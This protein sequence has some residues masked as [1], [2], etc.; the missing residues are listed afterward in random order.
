[1]SEVEFSDF[2][3]IFV[4]W[5]IYIEVFL[6]GRRRFPWFFRFFLLCRPFCF[7][8]LLVLLRFTFSPLESFRCWT[9]N[10]NLVFSFLKHLTTSSYECCCDVRVKRQAAATRAYIYLYIKVDYFICWF[11]LL[12]ILYLFF[13]STGSPLLPLWLHP[14]RLSPLPHPLF[15]HPPTPTT[16]TTTVFYPTS[17]YF[18]LPHH[19]PSKKLFETCEDCMK[20]NVFIYIIC[21][22]ITLVE[23]NEV[24][25]KIC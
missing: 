12:L 4:F 6:K 10:F 2:I 1:M 16:T 18:P 9:T 25:I 19:P 24:V 11:R 15:C 21:R 14:R 5:D 17:F 7:F 8:V 20:S 23:W 13:S 22:Q 3:I